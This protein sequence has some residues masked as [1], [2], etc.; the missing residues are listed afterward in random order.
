MDEVASELLRK[1]LQDLDVV[2]EDDQ[3]VPTPLMIPDQVLAHCEL[4]GV[5]SPQCPAQSLVARIYSLQ[6]LLEE[7][8]RHV[9]PNFKAPHAGKEAILLELLPARLVELR[10]NQ[11]VEIVDEVILSHQGCRQPHAAVSLD[12]SGHRPESPCWHHLHLVHNH[13]A[14]LQ[15]LHLRE[16]KLSIL[17]ALAAEAHHAVSR[18][19]NAGPPLG[20]TD[21]P[22]VLRSEH[23]DVLW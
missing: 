15:L 22:L 5:G 11:P 18:Y 6:V 2:A 8:I 13:E 20:I 17:A 12:S 14:P 1:L 4:V 10:S 9:A 7:S 23:V 16:N 19:Q 3:L 21:G